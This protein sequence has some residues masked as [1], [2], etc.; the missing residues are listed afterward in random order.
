[1][2]VKERLVALS[3]QMEE[4]LTEHI[5]PY[6]I[7]NTPDRRRG[8]FVGRI[9]GHN[10]IDATADRGVVLNARI[11]W[12]F[13]A[14]F[15]R[16]GRDSYAQMA[17]RA[18][19]YL[20]QYFWDNEFGGLFWMVNRDGDPVD[21]R[22]LVYGQ[23]FGLYGLSEYAIATKSEESAGYAWRL[24]ESIENRCRDADRDGYFEV[25][26][27]SW[28]PLEEA[29]SEKDPP[30]PKSMNTHLHVLEAYTNLSRLLPDVNVRQRTAE[31]AR[32]FVEAIIDRKRAQVIP[33]FD[34]DWTPVSR[35]ISYGHDIEASWLLVNAAQAAGD[36]G[37]LEE[38]RR[39]AIAMAE[40]VLAEGVDDDGGLWN[41]RH[42]DGRLDSDK[43]WWPQAESIVGFVQAFGQTGEERYLKAAEN[44][45][46]F[47]RSRIID[48]HNGEWFFRVSRD[49]TP[50]VDDD[51]V[52]PWKCPYHNGRACLEVSRRAD[53]PL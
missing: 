17:H 47:I 10:E 22:K 37:L 39:V 3:S 26:D 18:Y 13:S 1:M 51:K 46:S 33:F 23:A 15:S 36:Q 44:T 28:G 14:A 31:L 38:T 24:Y 45:W 19:Q 50:Y 4:E 35:T 49:G 5:L 21:T 20:I 34:A 9:T 11:L 6:W 30:V 2:S 7:A 27:R 53:S 42:E 12:T 29:L 48:R 32:L 41:E 52:G 40:T 25:F 43:H 16:Y 8:G